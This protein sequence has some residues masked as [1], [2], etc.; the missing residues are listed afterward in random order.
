[1]NIGSI[2][3]MIVLLFIFI[4]LIGI[5]IWSAN[6]NYNLALQQTFIPFTSSIDPSTGVAK[7]FVDVNGNPQI[8]C[9]AGMKVN[10][11]GAFYNVFDPYNECVNNET[12]ILPIVPFACDPSQQSQSS[13]NVDSDCPGNGR[14]FS[15]NSNGKC[16]LK[17][18]GKGGANACPTGT[19]LVNVGS[20]YYCVDPNVC[21]Y[22]IDLAKNKGQPGLPNPYCSPSNS[23]SKCALRDASAFV[24]SKCDGRNSCPD[25]TAADFG[26]TPCALKPQACISGY[27]NNG[28]PQWAQGSNQR[29]GY[30]GLPYIPGYAGGAP[31]NGSGNSDP[32]NSNLG[33]VLHGI[34]TCVP[35]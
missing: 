28:N 30:C 8:S 18:Q 26:D 9:P 10:I 11:V 7:P 13:C 3:T 15:C 22:N 4:A 6:K 32:A 16:Q 5:N 2:V 29:S 21:G 1:M 31:Y 12:D 25:L 34:Y 27:D 33:Y 14:G 17:D 19:T 23:S 24:A 20:G 35:N